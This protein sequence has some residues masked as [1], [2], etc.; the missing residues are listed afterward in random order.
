[1][2]SPN[3]SSSLTIR[4]RIRRISVYYKYKKGIR[5]FDAALLFLGKVENGNQWFKT[6]NVR[7]RRVE[8]GAICEV[9]GIGIEREV[10]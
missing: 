9:L 10:G 4:R 5:A 8:D 2:T 6:I 1:M 7:R 3:S